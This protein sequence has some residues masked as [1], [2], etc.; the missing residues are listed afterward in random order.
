MILG[1]IRGSTTNI[2]YMTGQDKYETI[3]AVCVRVP[4][5]MPMFVFQSGNEGEQTATDIRP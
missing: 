2:V 1:F 4:Y 5:L 3:L